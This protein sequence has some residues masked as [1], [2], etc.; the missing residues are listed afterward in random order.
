MITD[1]NAATTPAE[2][3]AEDLFVV[4]GAGKDDAIRRLIARD[5]GLTAWAAVQE[6]A[7]VELWVQQ[8]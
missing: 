1:K 3:G 6:C 4:A 7:A 8:D 5:L 2:V